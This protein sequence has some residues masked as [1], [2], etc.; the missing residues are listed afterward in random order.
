MRER[1]VWAPVL[2]LTARTAVD[3]RV[4]GLDA[5]ADDYLPK[6]FAFGELLARLRALARRGSP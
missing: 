4:S 3:Y 1:G 5:G 6:P 2:M